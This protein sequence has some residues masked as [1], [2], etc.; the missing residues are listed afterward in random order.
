MTPYE[1]AYDVM[2][3]VAVPGWGDDITKAVAEAIQ[4]A[5]DAENADLRN[6]IIGLEKANKLLLA[7]ME[8]QAELMDGLKQ[9]ARQ[10]ADL[11]KQIEDLRRQVKAYFAVTRI[12][13]EDD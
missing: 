3:R 13:S 10:N 4:A 7:G 9:E 11:R 1:R 2:N 5:V 6:T 12:L 8:S